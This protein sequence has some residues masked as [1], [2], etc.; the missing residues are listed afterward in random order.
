MTEQSVLDRAMMLADMAPHESVTIGVLAGREG[1][2]PDSRLA[3]EPPVTYLENTEAPAYVLTNEKRGIGLGTKRNR[4]KPDDDRGTV[5]M[6]TGRRTV[7]LVGQDDG[8]AVFSIPHETLSA[9]NYNSGLLAKRLVLESPRARYH[10]WVDRGTDA[11]VLDQA[12][13]YVEE[14]LPETPAAAETN[15]DSA[16]TVTYRGKPIRQESSSPPAR[17]DNGATAAADGGE[18]SEADQNE[19]T[20]TYRG[21]EVDPSY[22]E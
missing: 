2:F 17:V 4:T 22:L 11:A 3:E 6:V 19:R 12:A 18:T 16:S 20:I 10:L 1:V 13:A 9:V 14:R 7:C 8:D 21:K 15:D 5:V